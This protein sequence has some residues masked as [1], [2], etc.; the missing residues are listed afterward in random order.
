VC[1]QVNAQ[2]A[3][4]GRAGVQHASKC[5]HVACLEFLDDCAAFGDSDNASVE[6]V[7]VIIDF[8]RT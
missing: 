7:G 4:H 3:F 1:R 8:V 2:Q 6:D 5:A